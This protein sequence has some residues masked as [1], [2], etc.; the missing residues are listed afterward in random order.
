MNSKLF[1]WKHVLPESANVIFSNL[2]LPDSVRCSLNAEI[3]EIRFNSGIAVFIEWSDEK[4]CYLVSWFNPDTSK[5]LTRKR[6]RDAINVINY[7]SKVSRG[8]FRGASGTWRGRVVRAIRKQTPRPDI[9]FG[10]GF[11]AGSATDD[12]LNEEQ[13]PHQILPASAS[14]ESVY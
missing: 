11:I 14:K 3:A 12:K 6:F 7:V 5:I 2:K 9:Y 1:D 13:W 8:S 10:M 4:E